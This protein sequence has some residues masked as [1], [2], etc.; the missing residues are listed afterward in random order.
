LFFLSRLAH[1]FLHLIE[2]QVNHITVRVA[3]QAASWDDDDPAL[4]SVAAVDGTLARKPSSDPQSRAHQNSAGPGP[5]GCIA[6]PRTIDSFVETEE[7]VRKSCNTRVHN[8]FKLALYASHLAAAKV[9]VI[10]RGFTRISG[11]GRRSGGCADPLL[12][13]AVISAIHL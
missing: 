8:P 9:P 12:C 1:V 3:A 4:G 6:V 13:L 7:E 10:S 5:R 11:I 2:L